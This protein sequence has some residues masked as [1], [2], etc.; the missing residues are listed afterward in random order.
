[1]S[2]SR[3]DYDTDRI[4]TPIPPLVLS[5]QVGIAPI[6]VTPTVGD[7]PDA[8]R[9]VSTPILASYR[10]K[11]PCSLTGS[12]RLAG[13]AIYCSRMLL[14]TANSKPVSLSPIPL[15][16]PYGATRASGYVELFY[17]EANLNK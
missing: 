16:D 11:V 14:R 2:I 3:R 13:S 5:S 8:D 7:F 15:A 6:G 9:Q 10:A 17:Y 4:S 12:F 1:M